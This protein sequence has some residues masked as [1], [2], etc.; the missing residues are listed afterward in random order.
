MI[1]ITQ[2]CSHKILVNPERD[3]TKQKYELEV[4]IGDPDVTGRSRKHTRRISGTHALK[5]TCKPCSEAHV[6]SSPT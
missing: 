2:L 3:I 4:E 5:L 6:S 1:L